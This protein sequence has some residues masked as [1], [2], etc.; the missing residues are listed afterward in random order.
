[1]W[2]YLVLFVA[3]LILLIK[4]ADWVSEYGSMLARA[5][6]VSELVI[7][8]TLV[9][10]A[11]S[12]PELAVS[13]VSA[14]TQ[15]AQIATGTIVGS[16]IS[17]IGL[18]IGISALVAPLS[19]K[20]DFIREEYIMILFSV[21]AAIF[22]LDG[23][24]WYEGIVIIAGLVIYMYRLTKRER[25]HGMIKSAVGFV[26][27][28][29]G[30]KKRIPISH[31]LY[32]IFG[33]IIV[34]AGAELLIYSTI[35]ISEAIGVSELIISLIAI[36]VGTSLPE[37]A[38]SLTAAIKG[39]R[40]ISVGNIIGSNIFNL[41]ILGMTSLFSV[42][43]VTPLIVLADLPIMVMLAALLLAFTRTGWKI[44]RTEGAALLIIYSVFVYLQF[45]F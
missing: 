43:P 36:A 2:F 29:L 21:V 23:M 14:I 33:G 18:I 28:R 7:G 37:L 22:L 9:A 15:T 1:M 11:T 38:V 10:I 12:L 17:N 5:L 40:G 19:T 42:V 31:L 24:A 30:M 13:L 8:I 6:G 25:G 44:S 39:M 45:V 4:G 34:I 27:A 16:N 41:S 35:S 32:C 3:G 20:R 26:S